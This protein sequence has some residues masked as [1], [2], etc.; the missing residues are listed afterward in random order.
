ML[1]HMSP[2]LGL[3]KKCPARVAYKVEGLR[4][5]SAVSV[6]LVFSLSLF[7][8]LLFFLRCLME[9]AIVILVAGPRVRGH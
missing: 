6:L 2:P 1:R 7:D 3:G 9:A 4:A 8:L 5:A